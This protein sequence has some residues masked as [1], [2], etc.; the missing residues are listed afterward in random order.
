MV[1]RRTPAPAPRREQPARSDAAP[2]DSRRISHKEPEE[3]KA[4]LRL[5]K[6]RLDDELVEQPVIF[7]D[8]TDQVALAVS[9]R[10]QIKFDIDQAEAGLSSQFRSAAEG[11]KITDKSIREKVDGS[12]KMV[13]L[14]KE[15]LA[16][17]ALLGRWQAMKEAFEQ[18][19]DMIKVAAQL[20]AS[21]YFTRSSV[22]GAR[23]N[24]DTSQADENRRRSG[25][26]RSSRMRE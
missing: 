14:R 25:E 12:V 6:H 20:H 1:E 23:N 11:D 2:Q 8:I 5:D 13:A 16:A 3:Y 22:S 4:M 19:R 7:N 26:E 9:R 24:L 17:Q 10:D 15:L 18:R 21:G